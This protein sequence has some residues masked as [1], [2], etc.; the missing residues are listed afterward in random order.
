MIVEPTPTGPRAPLRR[1]IRLVGLVLPVLLLAGVVAAGVLGPRPEPPLPARSAAPAVALV[2]SPRPSGATPASSPG[3]LQDPAILR[4]AG[5]SFPAEVA[6]LP[7]QHVSAVLDA[8]RAGRG[9]ALVAIAGYLR[10]WADPQ[11]C[12]RPVPGLPGGGCERQ[13]L[14]AETSWPDSGSELVSGI[15]PH[16]HASVPPGVVIPDTAVGLV[17][18]RPGP[19][20]PVVVIGR[21]DA[22]GTAGVGVPGVE[23]PFTIERVAWA[24]GLQ[25]SIGRQVEAGLAVAPGDPTR[26][27]PGSAALRAI[28]P[29]SMLLRIVLVRRDALA[30][31][32]P[33]AARAAASHEAGIGQLWYIRAL[34]VAGNPG[35]G[36]PDGRSAPVVRWAVVA[37]RTGVV[38]GHG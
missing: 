9:P 13:A 31:V 17:S 1:A 30:S 16:L 22:P 2:A 34:A 6:N 23:P 35:P 21:F 29:V 37:A 3:G 33:A 32:D 7:V 38:I 15:G 24:S 11:A 10:A 14:L 25:E 19:P 26:A 27:G 8:Q 20:P 18:D 28:G 12:T 5:D 4:A 36:Q